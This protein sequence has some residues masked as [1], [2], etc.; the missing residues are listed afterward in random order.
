MIRVLYVSTSTT[1]GGAEKTLH[2]LATRLDRKKFEV[3]AV[4]SLKPAGI[5]ARKLA[6]SGISV[7]SLETGRVP[8]PRALSALRALI[9]ERKP[10]VVH[11]FMYQAAQLCRMAKLGAGFKLV[12]SPR[13]TYRTRSWATLALDRVLKGLDDALVSECAASRD[14]LIERQGYRPDK[15]RTIYNGVEP[16]TRAFQDDVARLR[17]EAGAGPKDFLI[18]SAGRLDKQKNHASLV[19]A[20]IPL[21]NYM[22]WVR[23]VI[24]GE[25][26]ERANLESL[27]GRLGLRDCV[28][29]LGERQDAAAWISSLDL[30]VLPSLWEGLPNVLLEAMALGVPCAASA[31][32]GVLE[33]IR[34][35]ES[36]FLFA[37][38]NPEA[39][40]RTI[41]K[42]MEDDMLRR[43]VAA[44]GR[45]GVAEKFPLPMMVSSYES[46]YES[47]LSKNEP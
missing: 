9:A 1:L 24:L 25:G 20:L 46:L 19:R 42:V 8:G 28:R 5:Y 11:A 31:V 7:A 13:V 34:D 32:D 2:T 12:S 15:V 10:D 33:I 40:A 18:G 16:V 3:P 30:F 36:G 44:R 6:E 17:S 38:G 37:P 47:V 14:Y 21:K 26:P 45:A 35:G 27:I 22:P 29:L 43:T 41:T 23:C 39:A 4:V